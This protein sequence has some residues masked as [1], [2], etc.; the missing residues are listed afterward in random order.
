MAIS[1]NIKIMKTFVLKHANLLIVIVLALVFFI[2]TASFNY[3][4]Q[5][6]DYV[7]WSSPDETANYFFAKKFSEADSFNQRLAFFDSANVIGDNLIM[8]RSM[9][10]DF[11]QVKPVSFLGIILLYGGLASI[12]GVAVIPFLTPFFAALGLI[13][14]YFIVRRLFNERVGLWSAFLLAVFP[15]YVYYTVRSMFHNV[16]FIV[17]ALIG[18][19]LFILALGPKGGRLKKPFLSLSLSRP[20]TEFLAAL[21]AGAFSG[22]AAIT[23]TSEL[24]WLMPAFVCLWIFYVRR[25]GLAKLAFFFVGL[26]AAF[27]PVAYY[28]QILYGS[29]FHGGYNA[30]NKSLDEIV[31]T[32]GALLQFTWAGQFDYYH[33]YLGRIFH[34]IFYFGFDYPQSILMFKRYVVEMFPVV[35]YAGMFGLLLLLGQ[36]VRRFRKKYLVY[37]LVGLIVSVFLVFYYGSWQFND[38]P[39]LTRFTIGNSYTRYWLPIYLALIPLAA[40]ALTRVSRAI[41]SIGRQTAARLRNLLATGLQILAVAL[42]AALSILFVLYGSEEGLMYLYYNNRAER[43]NTEKVWSLTEPEAIIITRYY[44]KFFFPERRVIMGTLPNEEI[45]TAASQLVK[46]YPLYYYNFY[47]NEADVAY[48]N[49]RKFASYGL[50]MKLVKKTNAQFGLYKI[51]QTGDER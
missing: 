1:D 29:F 46:Y 48:L 24:L 12:F 5:D 10:S 35:F 50:T 51:E 16:L 28:N 20:G 44:D 19:Y 7:K 13:I 36:N 21:G 31:Q 47:L 15:V 40:L 27:L 2:A 9:R 4:S 33:A 22:L 23:R 32:G 37:V 30:M 43:S 25:L 17:L 8:P 34:N 41:F 3:L 45:L 18:V 11:G 6:T 49:E 42:V 14:F 39:D 38:N 26:L